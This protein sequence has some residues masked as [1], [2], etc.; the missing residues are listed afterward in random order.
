[1]G[2]EPDHLVQRDA[3]VHDDGERKEDGH[4]RVHLL[5]HK[6]E[7]QGLVPHEG[8]VVGLA[9]G[10]RLLLVPAVREGVDNVAEV[11][12]LVWELLEQLDPH[13]GDG[14]GQS[15]VKASSAVL[16]RAAEP[17]HPGHVLGDGNGLR[18]ER[19]N[20]VVREHEVHEGLPVNAGPKVLTVVAAKADA[21]SVVGVDLR[22]K[23]QEKKKNNKYD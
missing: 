6:P 17:G 11:P 5:V 21:K 8:L 2:E 19:V 3:P 16:H 20:H 14:H 15:V 1:V 18:V 22:E 10:D 12:P 4:A 13:I 23:T 7:G 9:V